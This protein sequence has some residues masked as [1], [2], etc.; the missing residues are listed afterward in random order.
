MS[1]KLGRICMVLIAASLLWG[2]AG[3]SV[4]SNFYVLATPENLSTEKIRAA[5]SGVPI[6]LGIGP[7]KLPSHLKRPQILSKTSA[8]R[9]SLAEFDRWAEPLSENFTQVLAENLSIVLSTDDV[10]VF[11]WNRVVPI[12]YQIS[13]EV[14]RFDTDIQGQG[15]LI[16]RWQL[17][18][19]NGKKFLFS[20][21]SSFRSSMIGADHE[22]QAQALSKVL[23]ELSKEIATAI[24][25]LSK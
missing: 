22:A 3:K 13:M 10:V 6:R 23:A 15:N 4:P 17:F 9:V 21:R 19:D 8:H 20:H 16:S 12:D 1:N 14:I 5:N 11:P 7:I 25:A 2:C 24:L 18:G